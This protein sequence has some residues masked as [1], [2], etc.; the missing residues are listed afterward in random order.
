[1]SRMI[2]AT[3]GSIA[4]CAARYAGGVNT[5]AT[6]AIFDTRDELG[7]HRVPAVIERC[8]R[9]DKIERLHN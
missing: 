7:L 6:G 2:N 9:R 8:V 1:M 3:R 4:A 5:V